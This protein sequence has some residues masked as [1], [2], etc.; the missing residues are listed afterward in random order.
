MLWSKNRGEILNRPHAVYHK[1]TYL[2]SR[3]VLMP[4]RANKQK[5][6]SQQQQQKTECKQA[7]CKKNSKKGVKIV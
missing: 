1:G 5:Q 2:F 3:F 6:Q 4:Q 7:E